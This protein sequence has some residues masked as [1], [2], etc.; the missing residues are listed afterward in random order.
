M[1]LPKSLPV[2]GIFP[3]TAQSGA[4][5]VLVCAHAGHYCVMLG[6]VLWLCIVAAL[7]FYEAFVALA[8][9]RMRRRRIPTLRPTWST[10]SASW[11][12]S[13]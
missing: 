5:A 1:N 3:N 6:V 12:S 11:C 13:W 7:L 10:R 8:G 9:R 2:S 4:Y